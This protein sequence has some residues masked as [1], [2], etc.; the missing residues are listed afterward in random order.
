MS[1]T[2]K[3]IDTSYTLAYNNDTSIFFHFILISLS[4][5]GTNFRNLAV[6]STGI[7]QFSPANHPV[8][9]PYPSYG[10]SRQGFTQE[11]K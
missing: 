2:I 4:P 8:L 9:W 6:E 10:E 3:R 7:L 5:F 11:K 1:V